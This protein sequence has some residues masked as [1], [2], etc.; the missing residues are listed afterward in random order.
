MRIDNDEIV[1]SKNNVEVVRIDISDSVFSNVYIKKGGRLR[2]G[3]FGFTV[4][5]D[6]SPVF[7]KVGG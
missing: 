6:G 2:L 1:I 4:R 5:D 7:G 3:N